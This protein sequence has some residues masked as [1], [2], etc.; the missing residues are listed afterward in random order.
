MTIAAVITVILVSLASS[1]SFAQTGKGGCKVFL[2]S[3][4][5]LTIVT[6][7]TGGCKNGLADGQG[8]YKYSSIN[9]PNVTFSV[10]GKFRNGK[11]NGNATITSSQTSERGEFREN[12]QWN[13]IYKAVDDKGVPFE[14]QFRKG[15]IFA[16]CRFNG[17]GKRN[18]TYRN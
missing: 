9:D 13:T 2:I 18:C 3:E 15:E 7:Y 4:S 11:L 1:V 14:Y 5:Q 17:Q 10:N 6:A 16:S 12:V 8:S